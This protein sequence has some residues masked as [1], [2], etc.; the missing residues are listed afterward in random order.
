MKL[1]SLHLIIGFFLAALVAS[2][3]GFGAGSHSFCEVIPVAR[4]HDRV[5]QRLAG[6]KASGRFDDARS[7][8][9]G[10]A[11]ETW[12]MH[13]FYLYVPEHQFLVRMEVPLDSLPT[14]ELHLAG[15]KDFTS[16]TEWLGFAEAPSQKKKA[17]YAW[18]D[19]VILPALAGEP[20]PRR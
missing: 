10:T 15:L 13:D 16:G 20:L 7:F 18:F 9:D 2:C 1:T 3:G 5:I 17:V 8:P 4:P 11:Q 19:R 14:T 12:P 6:L